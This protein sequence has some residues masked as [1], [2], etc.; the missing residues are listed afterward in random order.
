MLLCKQPVRGTFGGPIATLFKPV[1][2]DTEIQRKHQS[3]EYW[4]Q[5]G[6]SGQK[7]K[8]AS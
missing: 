2:T 1:S 8:P 5:F 4:Q 7:N 6:Q 3:T